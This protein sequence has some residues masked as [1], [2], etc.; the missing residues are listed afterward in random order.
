MTQVRYTDTTGT[1]R[2]KTV[3]FDK[4][5][6]ASQRK[7]LFVNHEQDGF[8]LVAVTRSLGPASK[9]RESRSECCGV[10][11]SYP[12]GKRS[13]RRQQ[14]QNPDHWEIR[15]RNPDGRSPRP[16]FGLRVRVLAYEYH[17]CIFVPSYH[18]QTLFCIWWWRGIFDLP[19]FDF[20]CWTLR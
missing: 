11:R 10:R 15:F 13:R 7:D 19:F 20:I 8:C 9:P 18:K 5:D 14:C 6:F 12:K 2:K 3:R 16:T 4:L 1:G 17:L